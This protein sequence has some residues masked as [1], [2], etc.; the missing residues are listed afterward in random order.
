MD[1]GTA[2]P[3]RALREQITHHLVDILDPAESYSA[4]NFVRD[5]AALVARARAQNRLPILVGGTGL[6]FRALETGLSEMPTAN[7]ELRSRLNE[8]GQRLGWPVLHARLAASDPASAEKIKANDPQ[9]L[10]RALEIFELT[11]KSR[12]AHWQA[13]KTS[14]LAGPIIKFALMPPSRERLHAAI[15]ERF[16]KMMDEGLLAEVLALRARGDLHLGLPSIRAVGYRQLWEHLDG[17]DGLDAAVQRAI[18]ATRQ[19]SKRQMTWLKSEQSLLWL[20]AAENNTLNSVI[21]AIL[22]SSEL[23]VSP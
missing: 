5:A 18:I 11:G 14:A 3:P 2:K 8:E 20:N 19:Y 6:Y 7:P 17:L 13:P 23:P 21:A 22:A 10:I 1:I 12:S 9:R 15:A 16:L 4:A